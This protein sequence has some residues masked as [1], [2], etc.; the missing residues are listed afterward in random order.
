[1]TNQD[2]TRNQSAKS[3]M[4]KG[5]PIER[6]HKASQAFMLRVGI[7][8]A[9]MG[10]VAYAAWFAPWAKPIHA[11]KIETGQTVGTRP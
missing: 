6:K 9:L 8:L 10:G 1:M 4:R 5:S 11:L 3:K 7:L 2:T